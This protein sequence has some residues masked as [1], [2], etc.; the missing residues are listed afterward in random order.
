M[1]SSQHQQVGLYMK[2][3]IVLGLLTAIGAVSFVTQ[4]SAES[5][6]CRYNPDDPICQDYY[7]S[8]E[9][10]SGNPP[11]GP[12][13][14]RDPYNQYE[15]DYRYQ[16]QYDQGPVLSFSFGSG[17]KYSCDMLANSL[18]RSG[19]RQVRPVDCAGRD[20]AFIARRDGERLKVGMSS[21]TGRINS[22]R[23]Y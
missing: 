3:F 5:R 2:K 21:R 15:P 12:Y 17:Q 20:F 18:R 16:D 10:Y 19:Y 7:N 23:P 1:Q 9:D 14:P 6:Y 13:R 8:D 22:I 11:K 4:A